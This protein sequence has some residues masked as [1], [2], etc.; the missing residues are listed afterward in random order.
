ML[1]YRRP[2]NDE[3][4]EYE[5]ITEK[6]AE[7]ILGEQR[8]RYN[9]LLELAIKVAT[10]AHKGQTDKGGNPYIEHPKAVAAQVNN[11]EHKIVAY[12]HDVIEDTEITLDDLSEMGF[13]YRIVNSVRLLTRTDTLTYKEYLKRLKA[14]DNA[15]HVKI[16][17]LR[18]N[19]DISRIPEPTEKDYKRLEK[20]KKSLE[21][22]EFSESS[23]SD[24]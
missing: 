21:F 4:G 2:D 22:L 13:T 6:E 9:S 7:H 24:L 15:R 10:E 16:A 12:L 20:Y 17:D 11:I 23:P 8:S 14:D 1:F 5:E 18:H 19:M 3:F